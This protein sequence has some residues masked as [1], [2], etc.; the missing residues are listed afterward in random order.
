MG[1]AVE[2]GHQEEVYTVSLPLLHNK[3]SDLSTCV[4]FDFDC[5][6]AVS[7]A[8][9]QLAPASTTPT[10]G[11]SAQEG[12]SGAGPVTA[13]P[14][15]E[16]PAPKRSAPAEPAPEAGATL[17]DLPPP[18]LQQVDI[19]AG[20]GEQVEAPDAAPADGAGKHPTTHG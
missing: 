2:K 6:R 19:G 4:L 3:F 16:S 11:S 9:L 20:G 5:I 15:P 18:E 17:P 8:D 13:A 10:P 7:T 1:R 12:S 14:A